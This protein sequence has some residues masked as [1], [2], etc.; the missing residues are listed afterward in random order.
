LLEIDSTEVSEMATTKAAPPLLYPP[1][2]GAGAHERRDRL[3]EITDVEWLQ[4]VRTRHVE[5]AEAWAAAVAKMGELREEARQATAA[6]GRAAK[7]AIALGTEPPAAPDDLQ[8]ARLEAQIAVAAEAAGEFGTP[9]SRRSTRSVPM[10]DEVAGELDRLAKVSPTHGDD[11]LVFADPHTSG[12]MARAALLR[13]Y[14]YSLR[15][16]HLNEGHRFHDLRHTFGTRMAA[17]NVPNADLAGVDGSPRYR[18][19]AAIRRLCAEPARGRSCCCRVHEFGDNR[20]LH[21]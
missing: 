1:P 4:E 18:D 2:V 14:R 15:A 7:Q 17:A 13:C 11:E 21:G 10:A 9:K 6:H 5:L 12:P 20:N 3:P 8:P 19:D 16:A